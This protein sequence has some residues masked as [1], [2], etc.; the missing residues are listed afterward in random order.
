MSFCVPRVCR[1]YPWPWRRQ[2]SELILARRASDRPPT[3]GGLNT[4]CRG[5][6]LRCRAQPCCRRKR[7]K[8]AT[9]NPHSTISNAIPITPSPTPA[10]I[11]VAH[12]IA[13]T[14]SSG[15]A[16]AIGLNGSLLAA[17]STIAAACSDA[18]ASSLLSLRML[19]AYS[20]SSWRLG[21]ARSRSASSLASASTRSSL[22]RESGSGLF[23]SATLRLYSRSAAT[24]GGSRVFAR[25][26]HRM[27]RPRA[28]LFVALQRDRVAL[29][30]VLLAQSG[31][32][33]QLPRDGIDNGVQ[34]RDQRVRALEMR[35]DRDL[36]ARLTHPHHL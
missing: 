26:D 32:P 20:V 28:G 7:P 36:P 2:R 19:T 25:D 3:A 21:I 34:R 30:H 5:S 6:P 13:P 22:V 8:N 14:T 35:R 24:R 33:S 31:G 17:R 10:R 11:P 1:G 9:I 27:H 29:E 15:I 23:E 4:G 18:P 16:N 12:R